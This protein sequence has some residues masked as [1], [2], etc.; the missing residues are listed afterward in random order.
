MKKYFMFLI[1]LVV[2]FAAVITQISEYKALPKPN[3]R[4]PFL[5]FTSS[6]FGQIKALFGWIILYQLKTQ[7]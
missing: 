3:F 1:T 7:S 2:L 6:K 4:E 5:E